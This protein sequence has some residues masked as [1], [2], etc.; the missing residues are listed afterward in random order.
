MS[1]ALIGGKDETIIAERVFE[2]V[3]R[4]HCVI[5]LLGVLSLR[6]LPLLLQ[7][8]VLFIGNNSGPKHLAASLGTPTIG[9]H[10]GVVDATEWGPFGERALAVRRKTVCSPCYVASAS[11]CYRG[12]ACL[13]KLRPSDVF[14]V[15]KTIIGYYDVSDNLRSN[16]VSITGTTN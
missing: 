5:S 4:K 3:Q 7:I 1:I 14:D 6:E 12:L 16:K 2:K 8:A 13:W 15:C 10:S 9:I 11:D